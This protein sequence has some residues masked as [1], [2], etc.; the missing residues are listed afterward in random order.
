MPQPPQGAISCTDLGSPLGGRDYVAVA[1]DRGA[2][3][4]GESMEVFVFMRVNIWAKPRV[5]EQ[6]EHSGCVRN[7]EQEGEIP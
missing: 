1:P 2:D 5:S 3:Q 6:S 7:Q 4:H